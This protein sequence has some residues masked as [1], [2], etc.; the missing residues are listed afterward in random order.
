MSNQIRVFQGSLQ[1]LKLALGD[2]F[3]EPFRKALIYVNAFIIALTDIIRMFVDFKTSTGNPLPD[4]T[5]IGQMDDELEELEENNGLLS[6]D[7]FNVAS[8]SSTS[9][10]SI[11]EALT[12]ELNKQIAL[13]DQIKNSM[14][15]IQNE[16]TNIAETIKD[17]LFIT[18]GDN[19]FVGLTSQAKGLFAIITALIAIPF[20]SQIKNALSATNELTIGIKLLKKAFTP[21]GITI[22]AIAAI[23]IYMYSTNENFRN[24]VNKLLNALLSLLGTALQ[25]LVNIIKILT[26]ILSKIITVIAEV[27][28]F[29]VNIIAEIIIFIDKLHIL[30]GLLYVIIGAFTL[31]GAAILGIKIISFVKN[32]GN[33]ITA[34][35]TL[36]TALLTFGKNMVKFMISPI[37]L[38]V[39]A[40]VLLATNIGMLISS[41]D[42]MAGWQ[43]AVG[44]IGAVAG[45]IMLVVSAIAAFHG[46]WTLG[47]GIA[48]ITAGLV[49]AGAAITVFWS[50]AKKQ[51][52]SVELMKDGG[53][54]R[55]GSMFIAGEAG[56][57][58]VTNMS[59]GKTG[60][61]NISQ[62]RT[63]MLGA[64][65]DYNEIVGNNS[66]Q[67]KMQLDINVYP[68]EMAR[69]INPYIKTENARGGN[70]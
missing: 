50:N 54:P 7:K 56:A 61:T 26:P 3:A 10:L 64:L 39:S 66:S 43:R 9:D 14:G 25:P 24:S 13:Y 4:G 58:F 57:E 36:G 21:L 41:W 62:F 22:M 20:V 46:A 19:K 18:D 29:M 44:I 17:W 47:T 49:A 31:L 33:L 40:V 65:L 42:N 70:R 8:S 55:V 63:A 16:A 68:R 60:V 35:K 23:V 11:T 59:N 67:N 1:N 45:A 51:A 2:T 27:I 12:E 5:I 34:I 48:A 28:A 69:A 38:A 6:F 32:I 37:G 30:D 15:D 52:S 53:M